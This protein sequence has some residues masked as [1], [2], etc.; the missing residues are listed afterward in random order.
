MGLPPIFASTSCCHRSFH[1]LL[2]VC[3][4]VE[5][6]LHKSGK[7]NRK[8][9]ETEALRD[10]L[11]TNDKSRYY[12]QS[13]FCK[14]EVSVLTPPV[15][16]AQMNTNDSS[17]EQPNPYTAP[18][19]RITNDTA[20]SVDWEEFSKRCAE[21]MVRWRVMAALITHCA[22]WII[23]CALLFVAQILLGDGTIVHLH[24]TGLAL[25]ILGYVATFVLAFV[26]S[27][28]FVFYYFRYR[29]IENFV[30]MMEKRQ[31]GVSERPLVFALFFVC[32]AS[33]FCMSSLNLMADFPPYTVLATLVAFPVVFLISYPM[34]R[35]VIRNNTKLLEAM[36]PAKQDSTVARTGS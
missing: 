31:N 17:V 29:N 9:T 13:P 27:K 11:D 8:S 3:S 20:S 4:S 14:A 2:S 18:R 24:S 5:Q 23:N 33:L 28:L 16:L 10:L 7:T 26:G 6:R 19:S 22:Y 32:I 21:K 35:A 15:S 25:L 30:T 12:S 34:C 1:A 36:S